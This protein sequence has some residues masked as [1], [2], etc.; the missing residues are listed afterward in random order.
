MIILL[1][2]MVS[3]FGYAQDKKSRKEIRKEKE[4]ARAELIK[5]AVNSKQ[6]KFEGHW[7]Y[8]LSAQRI[9]LI[10]SQNILVVDNDTSRAQMPFVGTRQYSNAGP[11]GINF[12]GEMT[13]YSM[14]FDETRQRYE[15][16]YKMSAKNNDSFK[17]LLTIERTGFARL[18]ID[19]SKRTSISYDGQIFAYSPKEK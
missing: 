10:G 18:I 3:G 17:V 8:P 9:S 16:K 4:E 14:T 13:D 7:M 12:D 6:F 11:P 1:T 19:S 15:I 2:V 5:T